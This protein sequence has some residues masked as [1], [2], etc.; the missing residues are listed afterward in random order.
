MKKD[1][2]TS[3]TA[4]TYAKIARISICKLQG[5]R[6]VCKSRKYWFKNL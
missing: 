5:T 1:S 6:N 3:S 4:A 2:N